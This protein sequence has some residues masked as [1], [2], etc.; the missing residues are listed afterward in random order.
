M[1]FPAKRPSHSVKL[2]ISSHGNWSSFSHLLL[3][4]H[5]RYQINRAYPEYSGKLCKYFNDDVEPTLM[6]LILPS[7]QGVLIQYAQIWHSDYGLLI[8]ISM[9]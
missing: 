1:F 2:E 6:E 3:T 9:F 4:Q 5:R 8:L 7:T